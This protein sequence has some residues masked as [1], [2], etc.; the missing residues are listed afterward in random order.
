ML[1]VEFNCGVLSGE[2]RGGRGGG[3]DRSYLEGS[4]WFNNL[5]FLQHTTYNIMV[6]VYRHNR[7]AIG[8]H[9]L[10]MLRIRRMGV[11]YML[12]GGEKTAHT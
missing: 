5:V 9:N 8:D 4:L 10:G 7:D 11:Q 3:R 1:P 12:G 2:G 6:Q